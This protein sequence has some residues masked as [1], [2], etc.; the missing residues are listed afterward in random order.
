V[1]DIILP[2]LYSGDDHKEKAEISALSPDQSKTAVFRPGSP[3]PIQDLKEKSL[4][5]VAGNIF[6]QA[7]NKYLKLKETYDKG[8]SIPLNW[9]AYIVAYKQIKDLYKQADDDDLKLTS[10]VVV[11]NNSFDSDKIRLSD[12]DGK[13]RNETYLKNLATD[14]FVYEAKAI[15]LDWLEKK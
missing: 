3:L 15:M 11:T 13:E 8:R 4:Q 10:S 6:F 2:D 14:P 9:P 12:E 1:P 5:R 7:V